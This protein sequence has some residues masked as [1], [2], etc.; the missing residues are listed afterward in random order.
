MRFSMTPTS[1]NA[2][3]SSTLQ[4]RYALSSLQA[5]SKRIILHLSDIGHLNVSHTQS[6]NAL[7]KTKSHWPEEDDDEPSSEQEILS[8][9]QHNLLF[10][11]R[12]QL[13]PKDWAPFSPRTRKESFSKRLPYEHPRPSTAPEIGWGRGNSEERPFTDEDRVRALKPVNT[14]RNAS[15]SLHPYRRAKPPPPVRKAPQPVALMILQDSNGATL[16]PIEQV[17]ARSAYLAPRKVH[18]HRL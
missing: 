16:E 10:G 18:R 6:M 13:R 2:N 17:K 12:D 11:G 3:Y 4:A 5:F 15:V 7:R 8:S 1:C 9:P 14:P